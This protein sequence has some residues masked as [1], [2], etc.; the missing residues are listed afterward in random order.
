VK[1]QKSTAT[2]LPRRSAAV[3]GPLVNQAVAPASSGRRDRTGSGSRSRNS[4]TFTL[5]RRAGPAASH[6]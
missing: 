2:T 4:F 1:V 5:H 6:P 3:S